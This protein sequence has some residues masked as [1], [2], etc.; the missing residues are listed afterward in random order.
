MLISISERFISF[1]C[2]SFIGIKDRRKF[3]DCLKLK[4]YK[5]QRPILIVL[6]SENTSLSIHHSHS[7]TINFCCLLGILKRT[8]H[9]DSPFWTNKKEYGIPE[10]ETGF[11]DNESK[12]PTYWNTPFTKICL[13]MKIK[14]RPTTRFLVLNE[15]AR[16]LYALIADDKYRKTKVGR[17]AWKKLIG[18]EASLQL[19]CYREFFEGKNWLCGRSRKRL[20]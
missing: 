14:G 20:P 13:I 1:H 12:L 8:F 18:P 17:G 3:P 7:L 6:P 4:R 10:R 15:K 5:R 19:S 9:Y 11:D 2:G 16:S